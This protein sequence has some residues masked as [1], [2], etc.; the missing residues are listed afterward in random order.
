[1]NSKK[2]RWLSD[3]AYLLVFTAVAFLIM[4]DLLLPGNIFKL[5]MVA[6]QQT[7]ID[8]T[9]KYL[10]WKY[11]D[12][13]GRESSMTDLALIPYSLLIYILNFFLPVWLIQKLF[14]FLI[15]TLSGISAYRLCP[16]NEQYGKF[17]AGLIYAVNPW[18]YVRFL[19]G[20]DHLLLG[21][22]IL[23]FFI[24]SLIDT[25]EERSSRNVIVTGFF[26]TLITVF[27]LHLAVISFLVF[28]VFFSVNLMYQRK[29]VLVKTASLIVVC[30]LALNFYWIYP[31]FTSQ[32]KDEVDHYTPQDMNAF[33]SRRISN[34]NIASTIAG[35]YGFWRPGYIHTKDYI[36]QW[37]FLF[38]FILYLAVHGFSSNF[39]DR[40][41]KS[42]LLLAVIG[43][44]LGMGVSGG[45]FKGAFTYLFN[46][47]FFFKGFR[48]PH[49]FVSLL[50]LAYSFLGGL[51]VADF[52]RS[53]KKTKK[54]LT[55]YFLGSVLIIAFV[56]PLVYTYPILF[57]FQDQIKATDYPE[58]WYQVEDYFNND[59]DDFNILFL[60]WHI[61]MDFDWIPNHDK[62]TANPAMYFFSKP[63]IQGD[64]IEARGI[65]S[66]SDNP[67][68]KYIEFIL[69]NKQKIKNIGRWLQ[70]INVRYIVLI[71]ESDYQSYGF[72]PEQKDLEKTYENEDFIVFKNKYP[73]GLIYEVED[74][75]SISDWGTLWEYSNYHHISNETFILAG[76][77]NEIPSKKRFIQYEK[78]TP[79]KY[80]LT[81]QP[82]SKYILFTQSYSKYWR[83]NGEQAVPNFGVT[84][85]FK[86]SKSDTY[87]LEYKKFHILKV[88]Y[89]VSSVSFAIMLCWYISPSRMRRFLSIIVV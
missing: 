14:L 46:T 10:G 53:L 42:F 83:L 24:K 80:K 62:R 52:S 20:H 67:T 87:T 17:Y 61:Y 76:K 43:L 21:Y 65:Y 48:E 39:R 70:P 4:W 84:N 11:H 7:E 77:Y 72:L 59:S 75:G 47:F 73:T 88:G 15:F 45:Y 58:T 23:P 44:C 51:G 1:M 56:T 82:Q 31:T 49:K 79:V 18:V 30:Y 60:P 41:V 54:K 26:M 12:W 55:K 6:N 27:S 16:A 36:K 64:N 22:A 8:F 68:S 2:R 29:V 86:I 89:L 63:V 85:V 13:N 37:Y 57:G 74:L 34:L 40:Y 5:D 28:F 38:V 66:Q 71:K 81:S 9:S 25:L 78:I 50:A 3:N 33:M 35:L 69:Q 32:G 19:A